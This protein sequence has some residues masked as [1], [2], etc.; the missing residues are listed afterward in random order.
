MTLT[1][2][3]K[4]HLFHFNR[5][6]LLSLS[7]SCSFSFPLSRGKSCLTL[8]PSFVELL[9][10]IILTFAICGSYLDTYLCGCSLNPLSSTSIW[11]WQFT[12]LALGRTSPLA[13]CK[14]CL[15]FVICCAFV[16]YPLTF[17]ISRS[18]HDAY[19]MPALWNIIF[20]ILI[21]EWCLPTPPL[22]AFSPL[23]ICFSSI[24][25]CAHAPILHVLF[26]SSYFD[27]LKETVFLFNKRP[28]FN[29]RPPSSWY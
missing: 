28:S 17:V 12:Y 15:N 13:T 7:R 20:P 10:D 16:C 6:V 27:G 19:L 26:F 9:F 14:S 1:Q 22:V 8:T 2:I 18:F 3:A 25:Y 11:E 23:S 5:G 4:T 24:L 29:K 21:W